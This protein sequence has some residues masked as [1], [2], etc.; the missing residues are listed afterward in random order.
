MSAENAPT[1][2]QYLRRA[3]ASAY[4]EAKY[5][6]PC[7]KATLAT[8][9]VRGEGPPFYK[10]GSTPLYLVADLDRW[11]LERLGRSVRST[12]EFRQAAQ[13]PEPG[14]LVTSEPARS[15]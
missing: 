12:S 11:A 5:N 9:A 2:Q 14:R 10:A 4:V 15:G 3:E 8:M 6:Q 7:A 13:E 1:P